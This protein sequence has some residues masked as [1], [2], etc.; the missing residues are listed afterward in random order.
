MARGKA[1]RTKKP[2]SAVSL[3]PPVKE[4]GWTRGFRVFV[5]IG[6]LG[7]T[8]SLVGS[9]YDLLIGQ[10]EPEITFPA[11]GDSTDP[12]SL[13]I[14]IKNPSKIFAMRD[15]QWTCVINNLSVRS[16]STSFFEMRDNSFIFESTSVPPNRTYLAR[17]PVN[18]GADNIQTTVTARVAYKTL[19]YSRTY[20]MPFTWLGNAKTP[21]WIAG[22][23]N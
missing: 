3:S 9:A 8:I 13:P 22:R 5:A 14:A 17:C 23:P 19:I 15:A 21:R 2:A 7:G 10:T 11:A 1:A 4:S 16:G 6:S 12:F 18:I 20:E